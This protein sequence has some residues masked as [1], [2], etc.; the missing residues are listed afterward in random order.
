MNEG[1]RPMISSRSIKD[2]LWFF[3]NN[4]NSFWCPLPMRRSKL[5]Q[6]RLAFE[7]HRTPSV[8]CSHLLPCS[9]DPA[10]VQDM[11]GRRRCCT[12]RNVETGSGSRGC[13]KESRKLKAHGFGELVE[14]SV[15]PTGELASSQRFLCNMMRTYC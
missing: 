3:S 8:S 12:E 1:E 6:I 7:T 11:K 13:V 5:R 15:A 14:V 4:A 10:I 2:V 9:T